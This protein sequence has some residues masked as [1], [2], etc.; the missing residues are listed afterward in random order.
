MLGSVIGTQDAGSGTITKF[1]Y[2]TYGSSA[3]APSNFAYTGQRIDQES[4]LYYYRARHYS[5][6]LGRFNQTDSIGHRGGMNLYAYVDN[7]PLNLLDPDGEIAWFASGAI[8][9]ALGVGVELL[10]NYSSIRNQIALGNWESVGYQIG[11]A[12]AGG[13]VAGATGVGAVNLVARAG[14]VTSTLIGGGLANVGGNTISQV[15][16]IATGLQD[17]FNY[18]E[19][20]FAFATG[21]VASYAPAA[22]KA[23]PGGA[24]ALRNNP[25]VEQ[26]IDA[27]S[28]SKGAALDLLSKPFQEVRGIMSDAIVSPAYAAPAQWNPTVPVNPLK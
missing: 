17:S 5:P 16:K 19:S 2:G 1:G 26:V 9:A 27:V 22:I 4:S 14:S 13:F 18:T 15:A 8:G 6:F 11:A 25:A 23:T 20:A 10:A 24:A 3:A 7:D 28:Q 21:S 12:A